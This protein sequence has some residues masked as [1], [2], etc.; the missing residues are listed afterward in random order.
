MTLE[1]F[2]TKLNQ[3][4]KSTEDALRSQLSQKVEGLINQ[5]ENV[6]TAEL[7]DELENLVDEVLSQFT[8]AYQDFIS[9]IELEL[10]AFKPH[11]PFHYQLVR[12][13]Y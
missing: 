3:N 10:P 11:Y 7:R 5:L 4:I 9:Y 12:T 8:A 13:I 6:S 2:F 1:A